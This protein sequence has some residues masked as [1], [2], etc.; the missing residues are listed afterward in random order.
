MET[1]IPN[2]LN[3][4][5]A[6]R[7]AG[8][9][10]L[11]TGAGGNIGRGIT[12]VFC[13]EGAAVMLADRNAATAREAMRVVQAETR[14]AR[15]AFVK[16]DLLSTPQ[17]KRMVRETIR[18]FGRLDILVNNAGF[19][20]PEPL[21]ET[22]EAHWDAVVGTDL[23]AL[24][25]C[26]KH[27]APHLKKA[28]VEN[29]DASI[30]NI[31]SVHAHQ[32]WIDDASYAA[33]KAGI[34]GMTRALGHE[35]AASRVRVNSVSPGYIPAP[36][37]IDRRLDSVPPRLRKA[38][39]KEFGKALSEWYHAPQPLPRQGLALDI[40]EAVAFFASTAAL[41]ITGQD[42]LVDGGHTI[43]PSSPGRVPNPW[44]L[45][46]KAMK[47]WLDARMGKAEGR[48]PKTERRP[49]IEIRNPKQKQTSRRK[50]H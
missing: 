22:P 15:M 36:D 40:G 44:P 34:V 45:H 1:L 46:E 10:A 42:L 33:S 5:T 8:K 9:V 2:K 27:A 24:W 29:D 18:R 20:W 41:F 12:R 28:A 17:I 13:R 3:P 7:L 48:N 16:T 14:G 31:A 43:R 38:F 11:V 23:R 6:R 32:G 21:E 26:C 49:K 37:W 19:G 25:L 39:I 30:I 35:L 4:P 50:L 47:E